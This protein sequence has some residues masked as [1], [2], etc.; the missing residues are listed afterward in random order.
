[1]KTGKKF[2]VFFAATLEILGST[3]ICVKDKTI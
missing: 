1:M 3:G 2:S